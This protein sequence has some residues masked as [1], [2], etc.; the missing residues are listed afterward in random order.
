M[1]WPTKTVLTPSPKER[2]FCVTSAIIVEKSDQPTQQS[3][4][5]ST[6]SSGAI[7]LKGSTVKAWSEPNSGANSTTRCCGGYSA[8]WNMFVRT[9]QGAFPRVSFTRGWSSPTHLPS[10]FRIASVVA[11]KG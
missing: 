9:S 8:G 3:A 4:Q 10:S 7:F 5:R 11:R 2:I 6:S 1:P